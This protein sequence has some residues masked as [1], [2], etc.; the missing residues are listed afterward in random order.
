MALNKWEIRTIQQPIDAAVAA[1]FSLSPLLKRCLEA[2]GMTDSA[3]IASATGIGAPFSDPL[4]IGGMEAAAARIKRAID[5]G[6]KITVYGDYD[7]DGVTASFVLSSALQNLGADCAVY[8]PDRV[9]EG[10]GMNCAAVE[11]IAAD[12]TKLIVTVDCGVTSVAEIALAYERGMQVVVTDHH[13]PKEILPTCEA[14]VDPKCGPRDGS[15]FYDLSGVGL[16]FKLVCA[17]RGETESVFA[18]YGDVVAL[19]TV[20]D[21]VSLTME[22]RRIVALGLEQLLY[23]KNLG[24]GALNRA[25]GFC[26]AAHT[27]TDIA[28][29]LSPKLNAAGRMRSAFE[30]LKL[31]QAETED[32]AERQAALLCALNTER[33]SEEKRVSTEAKAAL[34][35]LPLPLSAIVL[36]GKQWK[37]GVVGISAAK[38]AE[39]YGCPTILFAPDGELLRASGRSVEGFDLVAALVR[40]TD[41]IGICGGHKMAA[42]VT[43][44]A[45]NFAEFRTRF[46]AICRAERPQD[47]G[48]TLQIDCEVGAGD[49]TEENVSALSRLEPFGAGNEKPVFALRNA[50][51]EDLVPIGAGKHLRMVVSADG[52]RLSVLAFR[53]RRERF[54]YRIGDRV[55]LAFT[56]EVESYRGISSVKLILEDILPSAELLAEEDAANRMWQAAVDGFPAADLRFPPRRTLGMLWR[57]VVE[58]VAEGPLLPAML[59]AG[60]DSNAVE[61]LIALTAFE[62]AGLIRCPAEEPWRFGDA[63]TVRICAEQNKKADLCETEIY[64]I[65]MRQGGAQ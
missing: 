11:K 26:D 47:S 3:A 19:G 46:E 15:S 61:T 21:V 56:A 9:G 53:Q 4:L 50:R 63:R 35:E 58:L 48:V 27:A 39:K 18:E 5:C 55:D 12:G 30:A 2:R 16:A 44:P 54:R 10:Y 20:A 8:I 42:G 64:A 6:E 57:R 13:E 45:E 43:I 33:Q 65:L 31:L 32:D 38:L 51:I 14:I 60:T 52:R 37:H 34:A 24:L 29:K 23:T 17:L 7:V 40:A 1:Q 28:F 41:G 22:N 49:L 62:Q 36:Q 25:S 59:C